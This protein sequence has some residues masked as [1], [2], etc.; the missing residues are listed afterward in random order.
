[1]RAWGGRRGEPGDLGAGSDPRVVDVRE[2]IVQHQ[3]AMFGY[4]RSL[5]RNHAD[6]ED[7]AQTAALRALESS[8]PLRDPLRAK[9]YLLTIVRNLAADQARRRGRL[10]IETHANVPEVAHY[11]KHFDQFIQLV[12]DWDG[13]RA[14]LAALSPVHRDVL[15][16]RFIEDLDNS[17]IAERLH[18]TEHAARQRVY[19]ALQALRA[20]VRAR[21][22]AS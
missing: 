2:V 17:A 4:A 16:L 22:V 18:T 6:A 10:V 13:P 7:I 11:D 1:M 15:Y 5:T 9:W 12:D 8:S 19:R 14:A 20:L 21:T 3:R